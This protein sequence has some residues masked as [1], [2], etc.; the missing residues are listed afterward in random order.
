MRD[1]ADGSEMEPEPSSIVF[2]LSGLGTGGLRWIDEPE[3]EAWEDMC[4]EVC[5]R[6]LGIWVAEGPSQNPE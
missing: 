5:R 6:R 4:S 1:N 3:T 2:I